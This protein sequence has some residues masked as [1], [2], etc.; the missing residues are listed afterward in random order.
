MSK[1]LVCFMI[2]SPRCLH[3]VQPM[4]LALGMGVDH[5]G[6]AR[7][8]AANDAGVPKWQDPAVTVPLN[9][10]TAIQAP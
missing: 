10:R 4:M 1:V 3:A 5:P 6:G 8:D 2:S 7:A 9:L